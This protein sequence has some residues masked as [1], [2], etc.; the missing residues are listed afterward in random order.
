MG[1][2]QRLQ[3][4]W[5]FGTDGSWLC[6]AAVKS[7]TYESAPFIA[8]SEVKM[9]DAIWRKVCPGDLYAIDFVGRQTKYAHDLRRKAIV[10][11]ERINSIRQIEAAQCGHEDGT[12][13]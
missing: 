1:P 13:K 12:L 10:A 9:P 7:C 2:T 5:L 8:D 4:T 6:A 3:A 11:V